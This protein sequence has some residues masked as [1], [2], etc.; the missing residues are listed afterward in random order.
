MGR[1]AL[2][3]VVMALALLAASGVA[4]AV[5]KIGTNGPDTQGTSRGRPGV[6]W[7][8][9]LMPLLERLETAVGLRRGPCEAH[10][11]TRSSVPRV[12]HKPRYGLSWWW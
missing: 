4:L 2:L 5:N 8:A 9:A 7:W 6:R 3:V 11:G 10:Y 12:R 1:A